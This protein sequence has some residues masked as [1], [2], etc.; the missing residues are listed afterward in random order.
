MTCRIHAAG[1]TGDIMGVQDFFFPS[2]TQPLEPRSQMCM[3]I[4]INDDQ[5]LEPMEQFMLCATSLQTSVVILNGGCS[6]VSIRDND[7]E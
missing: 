3:N 4:S 2:G 1:S 6:D 7:G 5:I